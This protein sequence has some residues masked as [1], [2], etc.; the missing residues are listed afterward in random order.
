MGVRKFRSVEEMPDETWHEPGS[1]ALLRAIRGVWD[2]AART[3]PRQI[4]PGVYKHESIESLWAQEE[5]WAQAD[6]E[7]RCSPG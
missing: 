7:R 3:C 1:E 5:A 6:F 2:F 4:P